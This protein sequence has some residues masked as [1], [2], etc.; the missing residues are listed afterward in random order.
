LL[1]PHLTLKLLTLIKAD[2]LQIDSKVAYLATNKY[3]RA[4]L[5][6]GKSM[7]QRVLCHGCNHI[8]YE[9]GELKPPDEIIQQFEGKCPKCGRKLSLMPLDVEVKPLK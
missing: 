6:M 9:G 2:C 8:L 1:N 7:P 3:V 5:H 4:Q